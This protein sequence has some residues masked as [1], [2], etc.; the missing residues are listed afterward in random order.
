MLGIGLPRRLRRAYQAVF[1]KASPDVQLVLVDLG[2]FCR[3][4]RTTN[5]FDGRGSID[6]VAS[7]QLEGRRQVFLRFIE[8]GQFTDEELDMM[9]ATTGGEEYD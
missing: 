3:Y 8:W 5:V 1:N 4:Q 7:A 9:Q 6:P 2:I